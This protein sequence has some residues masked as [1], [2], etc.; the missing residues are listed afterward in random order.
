MQYALQMYTLREHIT[1]GAT[2]IVALE[3]VKAMGYDG[4]EFAGFF[5]LPAE[6]LARELKR[7]GL[8][9]VS[10]HTGEILGETLPA[11]LAY[12]D[13]L[14]MRRL[15]LPYSVTDTRAQVDTTI[16]QLKTAAAAASAYGIEIAYHNHDHEFL[17]LAVDAD[18]TRPIDL[19]EAACL[20]EPDLYW[21]FVAGENP[22]AYLRAHRQRIGVIHLKDGDGTHARL[23]ALGDGK[24][25]IAAIV[26]TAR[27]LD[28]PWGIVENDAP[29]P[30]GF[31]NA[32][33]SLVF[34]RGLNA[35]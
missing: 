2:L 20:L 6:E 21:V 30:D 4:V 19:I 24:N 22:S 25:E 11:I 9:P 27:E 34:L 35:V 28:I 3:R 32:Q 12:A 13:A 14:D 26:K 31:T 16:A 8:V 5:G 17:P 1:D 15:A 29:T 7:I 18:K 10:A 23:D 33:R